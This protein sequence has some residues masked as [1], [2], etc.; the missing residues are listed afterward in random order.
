MKNQTKQTETDPA[1]VF[2]V[3]KNYMGREIIVRI[4]Y[5]DILMNYSRIFS[6]LYLYLYLIKNRP[7][8]LAMLARKLFIQEFKFLIKFQII[9]LKTK[10]AS[11]KMYNKIY[12]FTKIT[13]ANKQ[14]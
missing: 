6:V 12:F 7:F 13:R 9:K 14:L 4:V 8:L 10:S 1:N 3:P 2:W 11:K 5:S